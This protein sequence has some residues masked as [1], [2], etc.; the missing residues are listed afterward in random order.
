MKKK[1][2]GFI[3]I[4]LNSKRLRKKA[5]LK[6]KGLPLFV[7]VYR[8]AKFSKL[9]DE[10]I[11]C[12]DDKKILFL[13]KKYKVKCIM[14]KNTHINGTERIAEAYKKQKKK[15]D[16]IVDIQ[17]DEPLINPKH[18]DKVIKFHI[19]NYGS[20][21]ILPT[22]KIKESNNKNLIKVVKN[23]FGE[24]IYM[25]RLDVPYDYEKKNDS[26]FKHLSII[27]FKPKALINYS[28]TKRTQLEKLENIELIRALEIGLKIKSENLTGDSF[29]VDVKEDYLRAKKY[30]NRDKLVKSYLNL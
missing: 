19:K 9:L 15:Y 26:F 30:M 1:I 23:V 28:N 21:I 16:F 2:I 14:T 29:S 11:V 18:I 7:H 24:I 13:A 6:L 3:P 17:G 27:S 12:C 20:D 4:K 10:L 8:R 22:L 25:S 5:L